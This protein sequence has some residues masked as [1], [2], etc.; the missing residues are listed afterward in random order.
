MLALVTD[1]FGGYGGI[2]Q[3][4][5]DFLTALA[6]VR[7]IVSVDVLPRLAPDAIGML[8]LGVRQERAIYDRTGYAL[9]SLVYAHRVKPDLVYCGHLYHGSLAALIARRFGARLISQL[10]GTEVWT[11]LRRR[12]LRPLAASDLVLTVSRDTLGKLR[13]QVPSARRN[14][15]VLANTVQTEFHPADRTMAR[16]RFRV[17]AGQ[18]VLLT[19]SRLDPR[20]GYKGHD[21]V[22]RSLP[23]IRSKGYDA[24]YLIAGSGDDRSRLELLACEYGVGQHVRFLGR[25]PYADLPDL[26]RAADLFV[27]ASTGEGFG[28]VYLE[29]MSCGTPAVGLNAGGASDALGD[30]VLGACVEPKGLTS[31]LLTALGEPRPD[32]ARMHTTIQQRFGQATFRARVSELIASIE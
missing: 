9:R 13:D 4:N 32:A 20:E 3:Y 17:N 29:A 18:K 10:H 22:I 5:R 14:A 21:R 7:G 19:V 23:E 1:A 2:A 26:Y 25:V 15:A 16:A 8:P 11:P 30:G 12:D 27:L 28:I 6:A 24:V 31:T